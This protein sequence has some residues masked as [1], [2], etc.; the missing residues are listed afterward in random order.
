MHHW[1][2]QWKQGTA[3]TTNWTYQRWSYFNICC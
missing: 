1:Y 2:L 3:A